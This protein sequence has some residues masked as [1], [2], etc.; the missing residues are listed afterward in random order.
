[1][2]DEQVEMTLDMARRVMQELNPAPDR[3]AWAEDVMLALE[4]G[5]VEAA[6]RIGILDNKGEI[7]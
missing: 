7:K 2:T 6:R 4:F 3:E 5:C 1:M